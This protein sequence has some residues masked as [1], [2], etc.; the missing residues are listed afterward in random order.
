MNLNVYTDVLQKLRNLR[1]RLCIIN[2]AIPTLYDVIV[3]DWGRQSK[4]FWT[5]FIPS[6]YNIYSKA[7]HENFLATA[8]NVSALQ[9]EVYCRIK[10]LRQS[11]NS[12]QWREMAES[13]MKRRSMSSAGVAKTIKNT[14]SKWNSDLLEAW[15]YAWTWQSGSPQP[16]Q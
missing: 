10:W 7:Q 8:L 11:W 14:N 13:N 6:G 9:Q 5:H 4:A 2:Y 16:R 3:L 1:R 12:S 15:H